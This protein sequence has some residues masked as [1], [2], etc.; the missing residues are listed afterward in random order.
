MVGTCLTLYLLH[1]FVASNQLTGP[2]PSELGRLTSLQSFDL[3]KFAAVSSLQ[4]DTII[5]WD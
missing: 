5:S 4:L 3:G 1:G 2:I